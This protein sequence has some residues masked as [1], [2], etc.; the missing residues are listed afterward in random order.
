M[1][2][3]YK[4]ICLEFESRDVKIIRMF[5]RSVNGY[6]LLHFTALGTIAYYD[7][8]FLEHCEI[9]T[10]KSCVQ[11]TFYNIPFLLSLLKR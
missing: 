11:V 9:K 5:T 4:A 2:F 6:N 8:T 10:L 1:I 7:C 3:D